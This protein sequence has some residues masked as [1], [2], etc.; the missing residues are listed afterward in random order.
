MSAAST[1]AAILRSAACSHVAN[2]SPN[3]S[4]RNR[5]TPCSSSATVVSHRSKPSLSGAQPVQRDVARRRG[6]A[7]VHAD[8][9]VALAERRRAERHRLAGERLRPVRRP[10][11]PTG[12]GSASGM[13]PAT[14]SRPVCHSRA[15]RTGMEEA[16]RQGRERAV[17]VDVDHVSNLPRCSAGRQATGPRRRATHSARK[18]CIEVPAS[19]IDVA[20]QH[21]RMRSSLGDSSALD[22]SDT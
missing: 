14:V 3:A 7:H 5:H 16:L 8:P 6:Q 21:A 10:T 18:R 1:P 9:V 11:A 17:R 2:S 4:N 19:A 12:I 15:S 22:H 13:R 20:R